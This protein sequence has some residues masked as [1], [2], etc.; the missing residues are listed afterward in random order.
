MQ[1]N[2]SYMLSAVWAVPG[3]K[4]HIRINHKKMQTLFLQCQL[5][6]NM[7][8][9]KYLMIKMYSVIPFSCSCDLMHSLI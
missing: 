5:S 4:I 3:Q 6:K 2:K 8:K 1:P 9:V 7:S